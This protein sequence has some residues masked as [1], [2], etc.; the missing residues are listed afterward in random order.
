[1]A[2]PVSVYHGF[3]QQVAATAKP[4]VAHTP[5]PAAPAARP[6]AATA[7]DNRTNLPGP[8]AKVTTKPLQPG[9]AAQPP[10]VHA[11]VPSYNFPGHPG[12]AGSSDQITASGNIVRKTADG[13]V[14]DVRNPR[15]GVSI[16]HSLDGSRSI[17]VDRA[18]DRTRVVIPAHGI[19]YVQ[20]T[21]NEAG[22][23]ID[24]RTFVVHGQTFHQ[25]YRPYNFG[26]NTL[27]VYATS[28]YYAPN[29]YQWADTK[30]KQ[31]S[32]FAWHYT[33]NETGWY[34]HYRRFFTPESAYDTPLV[35][36][37]D[38]MLG[39][40][41]FVAHANEDQG[42]EAPLEQVD[43][44]TS[45]VKSRLAR[46][47]KIQMRNEVAEAQ[48]VAS[49]RQF[50]P[51]FGSIAQTLSDHQPHTFLVASHLSLTDSTGR[52][53]EMSEGD[54]VDV[55]S[56]PS[57]DES[58]VGAV[59]LASKGGVECSR[60]MLV[61]IDLNDVQEMQNHMRE[62]MDQA[63]ANTKAGKGAKFATPPFLSTAP[64]AEADAQQQIE[65]ERARAEAV[66]S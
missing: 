9:A 1:V 44:I 54:V 60:S 42:A 43:P 51:G 58:A 16:H 30:F 57:A 25:F 47:V 11:P 23:Q 4:Q 52:L 35:W 65:T 5:A 53:C 3:G 64:P 39:A 56:S 31:P 24:H 40:T 6:A 49:N 13:K 29:L 63:L 26:R 19:Q 7:R 22:R 8:A 14:L 27:D 37:A 61:Q 32:N 33:A 18:A 2:Q 41:L 59:V 62:T 45:D 34:G 28:R 15:D 48:E 38:Y 36:I 12:P 21:Y 46:E 50:A 10:L 55:L 17:T 20:H 66:E